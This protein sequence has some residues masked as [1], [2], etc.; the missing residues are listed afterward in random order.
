MSRAMKLSLIILCATLSAGCVKKCSE[1]CEHYAKTDVFEV[2]GPDTATIKQ[3][4][5][6]Q[7]SFIVYNGCGQFGQFQES[8]SGNTTTVEVIALYA[9]C[10]C[11]HDIPRRQ[12]T[13]TFNK[14]QPGTYY[15]QFRASATT[16]I[17][18]TITI[19]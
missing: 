8:T 13:F 6:F 9:G 5:D 16:F 1:P 4:I 12:T 3:D 10:F 18:D 14:E 11:T 19:R 2:E 15:L 17:R 7:V